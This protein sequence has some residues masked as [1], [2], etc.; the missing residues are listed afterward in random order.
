MTA[1]AV[2]RPLRQF[3]HAPAPAFAPARDLSY[4]S[5]GAEI[6]RVARLLGIELMPWQRLVVDVATEYRLD[7]FGRR[8]YHYR[9]VVVSVPRQS[10]KTT[11]MGPVRLHRIM[12]R[13]GIDCFSTAQT[14]KD[15]RS[16]ILKLV[17]QVE[18]SP[19]SPLF[20]PLRSNGAEGLQ[21]KAN[22]SKVTRFSPVMGALH[23]ETPH[24]VDFDEIWRYTETL[25]DALLGGAKPGM[26][27][28]GGQGQTWM[29]ST[30]G[31]AAST[32]MNRYVD[33]GEAGTD[34]TLAYFAWQMPAKADPDDPATWWRF[35]PALGNTITEDDLA[36][37]MYADGVS[38]S[39]RIRAYMNLITTVS[40]S[41]I[42]PEAWAGLAATPAG[43]PPALRDV[44]IAYEVAPGNACAAVVAGW[45]DAE[46]APCIRV[47]HQAPGTSWLIGYLA[48]LRDEYGITEVAAD[49]AGPA[50]RI[51]DDLHPV[52]QAGAERPAGYGE[53][54]LPVRRLSLPDRQT[55][56]L[57][58]LAAARDERVLK[59]DGARVLAQAV[60]AAQLRTT[61]GVERIDRDKSVGPVPS[62]IAGSLALWHAEHRT[63]QGAAVQ[64][65]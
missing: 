17:E 36:A 53:I 47:L 44:G 55:A 49:D 4:L 41:I 34:P 33:T 14:G 39:E 31:T 32:F 59:H 38:T 45:Y 16:R 42:E 29:I 56:D 40:E 18:T 20:K 6:A 57:D 58:L 2:S 54:I 13:P 9:T 23:G 5:E 24:L 43:G 8:I 1:V 65:W 10:G 15:A 50:R 62:L 3:D 60:A 11:L 64:L 52:D 25:G 28:L 37:E 26:I 63:E 22:G 12:T 30:K 48:H 27:T 61:N 21:V 7:A 51:S 46:G 19:L 35:H